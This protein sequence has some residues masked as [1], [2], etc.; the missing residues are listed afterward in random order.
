MN[1]RVQSATQNS[2]GTLADWTMTILAVCFGGASLVA[3]AIFL[4]AGPPGMI[5]LDLSLSGDI[6][7]NAGLSVLFFVQHSGMVRQSFK[8]WLAR[9]IPQRY[10]GASYAIVSGITLLAVVLVWQES[11]QVIA[12]ATGVL[13][14]VTRTLFFL[15]VGGVIWGALALQGFDSFGLKAIRDRVRPGATRSPALTVRGPYRWVRHPLY[16]FVLLMIWSHPHITVDRALFNVLWTL[17]IF[18]GSVLEERDLVAEFG[19]RYREYQHNV[20]MLIPNRIAGWVAP[21]DKPA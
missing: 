10:V 5:E 7:T 8:N 2:P 6:A 17:W 12:S 13:W 1:K 11:E 21:A 20:P 9:Y 14:W 15:A 4:F 16:F 3:F 19:E 18:T